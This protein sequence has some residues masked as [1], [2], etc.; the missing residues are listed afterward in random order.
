MKAAQRTARTPQ[1]TDREILSSV[2]AMAVA[3][4][5]L[6]WA[7]FLAHIWIGLR[8]D[9]PLVASNARRWQNAIDQ[10]DEDN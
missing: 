8:S 5:R 6:K 10:R 7:G 4:A 1:M 2:R 3:P 9:D